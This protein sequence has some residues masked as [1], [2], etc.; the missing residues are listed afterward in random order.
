M[1][2]PYSVG[3]NYMYRGAAG[4]GATTMPVRKWRLCQE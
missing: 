3:H 4:K 1:S 2:Y